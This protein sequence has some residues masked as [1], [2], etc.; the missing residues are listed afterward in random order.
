MRRVVVTG[1]GYYTFGCWHRPCVA[2]TLKVKA[3][4]TYSP[5]AEQFGMPNRGTRS[6]GETVGGAFKIDDWVDEK[7][8][9]RWILSLPLQLRRLT[10][11]SRTPV[12]WRKTMKAARCRAF[13]S[14]PA[15][16]VSPVS[17]DF[18]DASRAGTAACQPFLHTGEPDKFGPGHV[19]IRH[20]FLGRTIPS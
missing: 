2:P 15:S 12:G 19:S 9:A 11:L 4:S 3:V 18:G 6:I 8:S 13:L 10:R 17:R 20:G 14:V 5:M 16:V 7:T 1:M